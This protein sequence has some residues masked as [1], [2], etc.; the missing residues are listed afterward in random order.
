MRYEVNLSIPNIA[1]LPS[2]SA[3][4]T[5]SIV[6][7]GGISNFEQQLLKAG[8]SAAQQLGDEAIKALGELGGDLAPGSGPMGFDH[9]LFSYQLLFSYAAPLPPPPFMVK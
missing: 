1:V 2:E 3:A 9:V 7:A 6:N 4:L 5:Y 8:E